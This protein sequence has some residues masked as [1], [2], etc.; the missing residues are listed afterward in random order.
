MQFGPVAEADSPAATNRQFSL[1]GGRGRIDFSQAADPSAYFL[2]DP[3]KRHTRFRSWFA[4]AVFAGIL[5]ALGIVALL[6]SL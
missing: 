4:L 5:M 1:R 6:N 2:V 3:P